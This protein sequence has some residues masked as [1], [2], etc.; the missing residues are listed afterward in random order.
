[1][2]FWVVQSKIDENTYFIF[3]EN[4]TEVR[5]EVMNKMLLPSHNLFEKEREYFKNHILKCG[6]KI[7]NLE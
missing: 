7:L 5:V 3:R 4:G 6:H 2:Q 1:M